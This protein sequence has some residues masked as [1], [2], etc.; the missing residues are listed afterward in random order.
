MNGANP[1][2]PGI[3]FK[4]V[5]LVGDAPSIHVWST[6]FRW[7]GGTMTHRQ[8]R[9]CGLDSGVPIWLNND[10]ATI[11]G[12]TFN[13]WREDDPAC[14]HGETIR[15]QGGDDI[16]IRNNTFRG[17]S[18]AGSGQVFVTNTGT[19][20]TSVARRL[21]LEGNI[22]EPVIG[23]YAIQVI[24]RINT[25]GWVIKTNRFDQPPLMMT[26]IAAN[27]LLC[28]NTGQVSGPWVAPCP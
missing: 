26:S 11:E 7:S 5:N 15:V 24:D 3:V 10:R 22:I 16:T 17:P 14:M 19:G 20:D 28:G 2:V 6:D 8:I 12:M 4:N 1:R 9:R 18:D 21:R 13:A 23:T 25:D 27:A